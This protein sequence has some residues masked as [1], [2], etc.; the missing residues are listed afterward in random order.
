[1]RGLLCEATESERQEAR[2]E[3]GAFSAA[4]NFY[5]LIKKDSHFFVSF[6]G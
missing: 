5:S 6:A 1:M 2:S 4:L 3:K